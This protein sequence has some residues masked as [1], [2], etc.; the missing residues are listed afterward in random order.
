M[1]IKLLRRYLV[2]QIDAKQFYV[3]FL[4]KSFKSP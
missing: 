1:S 3:Y 4:I 2:Q